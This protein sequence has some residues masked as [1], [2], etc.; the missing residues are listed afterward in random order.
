[1]KRYKSLDECIQE[2]GKRMQKCIDD[3]NTCQT[4]IIKRQNIMCVG[5]GCRFL[6]VWQSIHNDIL[7]VQYVKCKEGWFSNSW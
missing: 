5:D 2:H 3:G 4:S 6:Q 7:I 1:M